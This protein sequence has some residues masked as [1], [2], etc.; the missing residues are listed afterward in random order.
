MT[1]SIELHGKLRTCLACRASLP[2]PSMLRLV[3]D[4]EGQLWPDL[5]Q[6]LPGR[7]TYFCMQETCLQ[8]M[9][10]KRLQPLKA[11][12]VVSLPQW[13]VL[14]ERIESVLEKQLQQMFTRMRSTAHVGRDAVMH[15]LWNNTPLLLVM[16]ADAGDA[17]I[18][19]IDDAVAKRQQAGQKTKT[20]RVSSKLWLGEKFGRENVAIAGIDAS[21]P[22]AATANKLDQ[23]CV[24]HRHIK[25]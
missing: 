19:Q 12:F 22:A 7:G 18:R 6:K 5:A 15:R 3:V 16:A 13:A 24:W 9:N 1:E 17:L 14:K 8:G 23:Y 2:K 21:G 11:K 25:A 10:D 20:V 4:D